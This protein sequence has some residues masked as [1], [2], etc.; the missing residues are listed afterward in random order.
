MSVLSEHEKVKVRHHLGYLNVQEAMAFHLGSPASQETMFIIE[1][2]MN[3]VL[4]AALPQLR[5][6]L[7]TLDLI[8]GQMI[9]DLELLAVQQIGDITVNLEEQRKLR[10]TY[11]YWVAALANLLGCMRNPFDKRLVTQSSNFTHTG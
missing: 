6:L 4:A 3:R 11:D 1:G 5:A 8:E 7:S 10:E 9:G 2:A